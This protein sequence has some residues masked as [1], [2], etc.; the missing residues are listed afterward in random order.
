MP[1]RSRTRSWPDASPRVFGGLAEHALTTNDAGDQ[2]DAKT[3]HAWAAAALGLC[4]QY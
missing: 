4:G 3:N 1:I 2:I